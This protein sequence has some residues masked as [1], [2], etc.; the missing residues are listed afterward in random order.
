M[1]K[2][3]KTP[4]KP[5]KIQVFVGEDLK[6]ESNV[7]EEVVPKLQELQKEN[8]NEIKVVNH[9]YKV[10]HLYI[11]GRYDKNYRI[12]GTDYVAPSKAVTEE[13]AAE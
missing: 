1:T 10:S 11:K 9:H 12:I 8:V 13:T 4:A 5:K 3:V 6:A 7:Y 2:E